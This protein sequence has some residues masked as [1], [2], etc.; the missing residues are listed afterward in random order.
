MKKIEKP[1]IPQMDICNSIDLLLYID[2]I[3]DLSELYDADITAV[4]SIFD[5]ENEYIKLHDDYKEYM[6]SIYTDKFSGKSEYYKEIRGAVKCCPYCNFPTRFVKQLDHYLPKSKFP[7]L[8]LTANNL[9][10]ICIDCN[11]N[12]KIYYSKDKSKMLIHPYYDDLIS[13]IYDFLKCKIVEDENIGFVFY[14]E[15]I[16]T[17]DDSTHKKV[18][19]HFEKLKLYDLYSAD[20]ITSFD[21]T[22]EELKL[23]YE[24]NPDIE[25]IKKLLNRKVLVLRKKDTRPWEYAGFSSLLENDWFFNNYFPSKVK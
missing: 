4:S 7:G 15:K 11:D 24:D 21:S 8:A 5:N 22:L 3:Q 25:E 16:S 18:R 23:A 19:K 9:V 14:I 10:P 6:V 12:K 20:F 17:W 1:N 13:N 2:R